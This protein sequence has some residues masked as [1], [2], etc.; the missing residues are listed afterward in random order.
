MNLFPVILQKLCTNIQG[1]SAERMEDLK[2]R[3]DN[4]GDAEV[5]CFPLEMEKFLQV[6]VPLT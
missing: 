5:D 6:S 1:L 4:N 2:I 3:T